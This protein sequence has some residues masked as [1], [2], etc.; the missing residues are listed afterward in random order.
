MRLSDG[1]RLYL[2]V[3]PQGGKWWRLQYRYAG[4]VKRLPLGV[5]P[6]VPLAGPKD[7][8]SGG[9]IEGAHEKRDK[10]QQ[11]AGDLDEL[12]E[13]AAVIPLPQVG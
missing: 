5:Y 12:R 4:K 2:E 7:G 10:V 9:L 8:A 1:G 6:H 13:G 3:S 11:W